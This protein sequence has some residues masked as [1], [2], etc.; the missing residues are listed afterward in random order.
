MN[1]NSSQTTACLLL[2]RLLAEKALSLKGIYSNRDAAKI[3]SVST[4][5]IQDWI[6]QGKF[7]TRS[8]PGGGR[9]LSEDLELFLQQSLKTPGRE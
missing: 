1:E 2:E 5:T 3:F 7:Q 6:R 8:L 9:F 4:R